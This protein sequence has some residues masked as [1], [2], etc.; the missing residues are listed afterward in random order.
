MDEATLCERIALIQS[1]KILSI[2]TPDN[3]VNQYP[4]KLYAVKSDN[5]SKL[6][7]DLRTFE[8]IGSCYAFGEYLHITF[9]KDSETNEQELMNYV[10]NTGYGNIEIKIITPTIE[11]CFIKQMNN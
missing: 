8:S 2:D 1:G 9:K 11:D 6:L 10:K 7:N 4:E 5:I 3:I